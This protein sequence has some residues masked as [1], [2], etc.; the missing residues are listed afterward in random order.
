[1]TALTIDITVCIYSDYTTYC[2][3][4]G[5]KV[6]QPMVPYCQAVEG[7]GGRYAS[8]KRVHE[9]LSRYIM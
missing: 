1:M 9:H 4:A 5:E 3:M 7:R 2:P 8:A 6:Y